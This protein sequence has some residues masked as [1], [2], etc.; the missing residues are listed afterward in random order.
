[1]PPVGESGFASGGGEEKGEEQEGEL[2]LGRPVT[3][4]NFPLLALH[5]SY[6]LQTTANTRSSLLGSRC[7]PSKFLMSTSFCW[8][9][10]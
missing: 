4:D 1:M 7:S 9:S 3:S 6:N 8:R 10:S 2:A 5:S